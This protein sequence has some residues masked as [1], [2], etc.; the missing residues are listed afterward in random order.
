MEVTMN[1]KIQRVILSFVLSVFFALGLVFSFGMEASADHGEGGGRVAEDVDSTK[2]EHVSEF[3]DNVVGYYEEAYDRHPPDAFNALIREV[4]IYNRAVRLEGDYKHGEV[5]SLSIN[6][7]NIVTN[8]ARYPN[9]FGYEFDP[10]AMGSDVA[11]T[12][13]ALIKGANDAPQGM[14]HCQ[15]YDQVGRYACARRVNDPYGGHLTFIAGLRHSGDDSAFSPPNC[16]GFELETSAEYV[17][18]DPTDANLEAY[19][20]GVIEVAQN[21]FARTVFASAN[22]FPDLT[23]PVRTFDIL[24]RAYD[25]SACYR[26]GDLKHGNIYTFIMEAEADPEEPAAVI[27]NGNNFDLNGTNLELNDDKL[28]GEQNIA[29]LFIQEL[30]NVEIGSSTYVNYHWDDPTNP[31]DNVANFLENGKVPGTSCKRSYIEVASIT[32]A[33]PGADPTLYIFGSGTYPGD[34]VCEAEDDDGGCAIAGTGHTYKGALLNLFVMAFVM[35]PVALLRRR[36]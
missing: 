36:M 34:D 30:G 1:F 21:Q 25:Q 2:K 12:I 9:L 14:N 8:H 26:I 18:E 35:F 17:H 15:T 33:V 13:D 32:G 28:S 23:G 31:N 11:S 20:K 5:Y 22:E 27:I 24:R 4:N 29:R 16:N 10:D 3:L 7:R 19:V 6:N